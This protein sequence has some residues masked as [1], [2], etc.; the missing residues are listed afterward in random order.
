M[1][2][3]CTGESR[4]PGERWMK[5]LPD[6]RKGAQRRFMGM[7]WVGVTEEDARLEIKINMS[8]LSYCLSFY[9]GSK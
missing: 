1:V 8:A 9:P 7:Q 3:T 4:H 6:R 2:W 5:E